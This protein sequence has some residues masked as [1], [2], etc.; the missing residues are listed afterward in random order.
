M[1]SSEVRRALCAWVLHTEQLADPQLCRLHALAQLC[2]RARGAA[3]TSPSLDSSLSSVLHVAFRLP[4]SALISMP[5]GA[6]ITS[7]RVG[8]SSLQHTGSPAQLR[9]SAQPSPT[10]SFCPTW[11]SSA[12]G[13]CPAQPR[14]PA[15]P[16][17]TPH[18][19]MCLG[20]QYRV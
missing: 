1:S 11:H 13:S 7:A 20:L 15:R 12:Q 2:C 4:A 5:L 10:Q 8:D 9:A 6:S 14:A 19:F 16:C 18:L 17:C 3:L